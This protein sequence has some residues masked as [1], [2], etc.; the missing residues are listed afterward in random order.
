MTAIVL[1]G[2]FAG[3]GVSLLVVWLLPAQPELASAMERLDPATARARDRA[4]RA[5]TRSI[6]SR[7]SSP[8]PRAVSA[9]RLPSTDEL[10]MIAVRGPAGSG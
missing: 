2:M 10:P 1:A 7:T 3:L 6:A 4:A 9:A 5:S 8:P